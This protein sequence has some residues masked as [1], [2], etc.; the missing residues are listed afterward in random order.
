VEIQH[1]SNVMTESPKYILIFNNGLQT[2]RNLDSCSAKFNVKKPLM[3]KFLALH[4]EISNAVR[5][6][7]QFQL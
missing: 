2:P 1:L 5:N 3:L 4:Q 7:Y 6:K